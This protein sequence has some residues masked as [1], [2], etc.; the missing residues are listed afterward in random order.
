MLRP[1]VSRALRPRYLPEA[2]GY[3]VMLG[4][5]RLG[6]VCRSRQTYHHSN[7]RIYH[8]WNWSAIP[9]KGDCTFYH[10]SRTKA[11]AY[12]IR[13]AENATS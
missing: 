13:A 12:L 2:G 4:N 8:S 11:G 5:T 1:R 3:T 6:R 7:G 10:S 9:I